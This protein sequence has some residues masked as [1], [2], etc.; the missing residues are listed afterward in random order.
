VVEPENDADRPGFCTR[1]WCR[2]E[3]EAHGL[4]PV[5]ARTR[6][7][8]HHAAGEICPPR[9][10][11]P[12]FEEATFVR[13]TRGAVH[14][15]IVDLRDGDGAN[16]ALT[17]ETEK[18]HGLYLPAGIAFGYQTLLAGTEVFLQHSEIAYDSAQE[19]RLDAH[20]VDWP[21]PAARMRQAPSGR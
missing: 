7:A 1:G 21:L 9:C 6:V 17:L 11:V 4:E 20:D 2:W 18:R 19:H 14:A 15:V 12:P 10:L 8:V 5:V 16:A 3:L 13:C